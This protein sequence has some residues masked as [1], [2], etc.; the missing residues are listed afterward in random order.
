MNKL[1]LIAALVVFAG[2]SIYVVSSSIRQ[3]STW[4]QNRVINETVQ[5]I[6]CSELL[7]RSDLLSSARLRTL[8]Q[9]GE[10]EALCQSQVT[11]RVFYSVEYVSDENLA[12]AWANTVAA[13]LKEFAEFGIEPVVVVQ[14]TSTAPTAPVAETTSTRSAQLTPTTPSTQAW[15]KSLDELLTAGVAPSQLKHWVL[16]PEPNVPGAKT[17]VAVTPKAYS[18]QVMTAMDSI[19]ERFP[20]AEYVLVMNAMTFPTAPFSWGEQEYVSWTP[21]LEGID[22]N[23]ISALGVVAF[24]WLPATGQSGAILTEPNEYIPHWI[25]KEATSYTGVQ[26]IWLITGTFASLYA[27]DPVQ[28]ITVPAEIRKEWL[29]K[30]LEVLKHWPSNS[31]EPTVVI[32][33]NDLRAEA[34]ASASDWGYWGSDLTTNQ[35]HKWAVLEFI[36][37]LRQHGIPLIVSL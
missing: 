3:S 20:D 14:N 33:T 21:Y 2:F 28:Q 24:P 11:N 15:G 31:W 37:S 1:H 36:V 10:F 12:T 4:N 18:T 29:G 9:L 26:N 13:D 6:G 22:S 16:F 17:G 34:N 19:S 32:S 27:E 23:R 30:T 35:D 25:L 5:K 7:E 8:R